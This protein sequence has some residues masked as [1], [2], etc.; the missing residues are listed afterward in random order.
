MTKHLFGLVLAAILLAGCSSSKILSHREAY[1]ARAADR[2]AYAKLY[3]VSPESLREKEDRILSTVRAI[4]NGIKEA[5]AQGQDVEERLAQIEHAA[6]LFYRE[7]LA[8]IRL[9]ETQY[10][11]KTDV[12]LFYHYWVEDEEQD[13]GYVV[14][15]NGRAQTKVPGW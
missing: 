11:P 2:T 9:L 10:D 13:Y 4:V 7:H 6:E 14:T 3:E 5:N 15:R 12:I 1:L 8:F